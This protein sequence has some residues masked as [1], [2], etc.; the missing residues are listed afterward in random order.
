MTARNKEL[1]YLVAPDWTQTNTI[2]FNTWLGRN[3]QRLAVW[4][5]G[6]LG[7]YLIAKGTIEIVT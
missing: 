1:G 5:L 3:W 6:G 4:A 2:R 7:L